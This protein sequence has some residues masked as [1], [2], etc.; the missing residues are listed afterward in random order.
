LGLL[1]EDDATSVLEAFAPHTRG[2]WGTLV[3]IAKAHP[4]AALAFARKSLAEKDYGC[5]FVPLFGLKG[6]EPLAEEVREIA[7]A[8]ATDPEALASRAFALSILLHLPP[9]DPAVWPL[10]LEDRPEVDRRVII[11][12]LA[13]RA[14]EGLIE[15]LEVLENWMRRPDASEAI[16]GQICSGFSWILRKVEPSPLPW[17]VEERLARDVDEAWRR[18]A[19]VTHVALALEAALY[20][21]SDAELSSLGLEPAA[22]AVAARPGCAKILMYTISSPGVRGAAWPARLVERIAEGAGVDEKLACVAQ[23]ARASSAPDSWTEAQIRRLL[24]SCRPS[25]TE[26]SAHPACRWAL[27]SDPGAEG[28][29]Q[30][31]TWFAR[32]FPKDPEIGRALRRVNAKGEPRDV[33][34][35]VLQL[36]ESD[37]ESAGAAGGGVPDAG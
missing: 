33:K 4:E 3:R 24:D 27:D 11:D 1:A 30:V 12:P 29:K 20:K 2:D 32:A 22:C 18:G 19:E 26:E 7:M 5:A 28:I 31:L 37:D 9:V 25:L 14:R 13:Q 17:S 6:T 21:R 35:D 34:R 36:L 10:L 15:P 16:L 8:I 23:L